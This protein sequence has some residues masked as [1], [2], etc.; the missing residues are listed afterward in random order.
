MGCGV[1]IT[2]KKGLYFLFTKKSNYHYV[3]IYRDV[4][5]SVFWSLI[6]QDS[7]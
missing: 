7:S 2:K 5:Y 1:W 3:Y 6:P 4:M